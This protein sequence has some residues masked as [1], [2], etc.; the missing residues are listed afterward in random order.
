MNENIFKTAPRLDTLCSNSNVYFFED[1]KVRI[2]LGFD[3]W[4]GILRITDLTNALKR[5]RVCESFKVRFPHAA[6]NGSEGL[7][8]MCQFVDQFGNDS[9]ALL[10]HLLAMP[11]SVDGEWGF[12]QI[13]QDGAKFNR[14]QVPGMRTYSPFATLPR[15]TN[16]PAKWT[17]AHVVRAFWNGQVKNLKC[18]GITTDDYAMDAAFNFHEGPIA[19]ARGFAKRLIESPG[20]WWACGGSKGVSICCHSFDSNE[21]VPDLAGGLKSSPETLPVAA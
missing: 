2:Q 16:V 1:A 4:E 3:V 8:A 11:W 5:G 14:T 6:H 15:L 21:F 9:R 10:A 17:V 19:D 12:R 13:E 20:G 18:N 7:N